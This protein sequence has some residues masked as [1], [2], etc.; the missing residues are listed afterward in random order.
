M[1]SKRIQQLPTS[2]RTN[3][4]A[5]VN[6]HLLSDIPAQLASWS[7]KSVLVVAS[8]SVNQNFSIIRDLKDKLGA[9]VKDEKIG[10]G[11]HTPYKDVIDIAHRVHAINADAVVCIGGCS[12]SDACKT[13]CLL[14]ASLTAGFSEA[15]MEA[16]VDQEKG[17]TDPRK[18]KAPTT[19]VIL[20]PTTLSAS[21]WNAISSATNAQGKKQHFG[22]WTIGAPEL[23]C[24]DP[25]VA[26]T[27]PETVWLAS[28]VRA[29]DHCVEVRCN[30][31]CTPDA[32][33]YSERG[34][35]ELLKGLSTYKSAVTAGEKGGKELLKGISD[36]QLG[37]RD[38]I[39]PVL[40]HRVGCGAS[41]AIG[42]QLGGVAGVMHG[43]TSAVMLAP[44][45]KYTESWN[46]EAQKVLLGI[47][48]EELGWKEKILG[49][50]MTRF[51]KMLGLPTT[52]SEVGV[53][54]EK[55]IETI[56]EHTLTDVW[57]GQKRLLN[58]K[59]EVMEILNMVR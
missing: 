45:L 55:M 50:A 34:L 16:I 5:I 19:K 4:Y 3:N 33:K 10:V 2:D 21:E 35:R 49:E 58:T 51:V 42:H 14:S 22:T 40:V 6:S 26:A 36:C 53:T 25:E 1:E 59:G 41:H 32:A 7:S 24:L 54:D 48:N 46:P 52:L 17:I 38:A 28:G 57:G 18:L 11:S 13:A 47:F 39:T 15:D 9:I 20:V 43:M 27:A 12:Y 29:V 8:A 31:E 37:S 30:S 56:A 44:V 23:I